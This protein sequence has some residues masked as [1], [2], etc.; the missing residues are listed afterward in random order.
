MTTKAQSR[1]ESGNQKT[2]IVKWTG[3]QNGD[4]GDPLRFSQYA[5]KSVQVVG[6]FGVGGSLRVEGS[7]DGT[8]YAALTDPQGNALDI[9]SAKIEAVTELVQFVRP[10][11]TGGDGTTLLDIT[12]IAKE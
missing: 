10:R 1:I 2:L 11:I 3:M 5:D 9:T 6:T 4:D 7:I 12:L 8:N